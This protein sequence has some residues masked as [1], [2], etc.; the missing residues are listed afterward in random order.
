[1][2][3]RERE[4]ERDFDRVNSVLKYKILPDF[5]HSATAIG[6][7]HNKKIEHLKIL[8]NQQINRSNRKIE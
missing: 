7:N 5:V 4:R 2:G 8:T 6:N 1:M 3:E